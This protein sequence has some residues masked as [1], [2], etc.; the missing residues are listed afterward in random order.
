MAFFIAS[1]SP[2]RRDDR[3]FHSLAR[4]VQVSWVVLRTVA[5]VSR[6]SVLSWSSDLD[7]ARSPPLRPITSVLVS[8]A[9]VPASISSVFAASARACAETAFVSDEFSS[10]SFSSNLVL[11]LLRISV[12]PSVFDS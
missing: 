11:R 4:V 10:L 1:I 3:S 7:V 5:A 2:S 9:A 6:A 8:L 12:T